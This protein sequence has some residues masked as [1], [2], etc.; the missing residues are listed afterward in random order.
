MKIKRRKKK[1]KKQRLARK[2]Y[3]CELRPVARR[4]DS[5]ALKQN[6]VFQ[7]LNIVRRRVFRVSQQHA[8][9][10]FSLYLFLSSSKWMF[11][12]SNTQKIHSHTRD[13][14]WCNQWSRDTRDTSG[15]LLS[16]RVQQP[17]KVSWKPPRNGW[18]QKN[19][20]HRWNKFGSIKREIYFCT[21]V[22]CSFL[23]TINSAQL[24]PSRVLPSNEYGI[25]R[26][27]PETLVLNGET[28]NK[29]NKKTN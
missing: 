16:S 27:L 8:S 5:T 2:L 17:W 11:Y 12:F 7:C 10:P 25:T 13:R 24:C 6:S 29:K 20:S 23:A 19:V 14:A 26:N 1:L 18:L 4:R 3:S 21:K 22:S 15:S 28:K 9:W